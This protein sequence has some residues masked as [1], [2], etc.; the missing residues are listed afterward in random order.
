MRSVH[1]RQVDVLRK[2]LTVMA[3]TE[4][5]VNL[6]SSSKLMSAMIQLPKLAGNP[7]FKS[8]GHC[9]CQQRKNFDEASG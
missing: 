4:Q 7:P 5:K 2:K 9:E 8:P 3:A 6:R 1:G